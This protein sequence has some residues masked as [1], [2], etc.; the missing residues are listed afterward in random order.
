MSTLSLPFAIINIGHVAICEALFNLG[1][2]AMKVVGLTGV[3]MN[4]LYSQ[5]ASTR[6]ESQQYSP[7]VIIVTE[8]HVWL[9]EPNVVV[10]LPKFVFVA[11]SIEFF[12]STH[13]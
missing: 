13:Y 12:Y 10:E 3:L 4:L 8:A 2:S 9:I 6:F 7:S 5:T 11:V 1:Q